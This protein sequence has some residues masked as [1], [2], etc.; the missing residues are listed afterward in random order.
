M[1][2]LLP[3]RKHWIGGAPVSRQDLFHEFVCRGWSAPTFYELLACLLNLGGQHLTSPFGYTT[4]HDVQQS[5]LFVERQPVNR[6]E[7]VSKG[8][9]LFHGLL[10][11]RSFIT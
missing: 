8:Y 1:G 5:F 10:R 11:L 3:A 4:L 7:Y 9:C 6:I 2:V